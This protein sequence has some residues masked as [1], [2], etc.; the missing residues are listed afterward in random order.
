[1]SGITAEYFYRATG[2]YPVDDDL[3]RSNCPN[4][5]K[6]MHKSCGWNWKYDLPCFMRRIEE[7]DNGSS[8]RIYTKEEI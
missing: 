2:D 3:E 7:E 6:S 1:M 4:A 5:G 8:L